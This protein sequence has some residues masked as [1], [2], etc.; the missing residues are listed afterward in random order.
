[1]IKE[2]ITDKDASSSATFCRHFPEGT[3]TYCSNHSAKNLHKNLEKLKKIRCE[4]RILV[5]VMY[6]LLSINSAF[7]MQTNYRR[8]TES[9]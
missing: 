7:P 5:M 6:I 4:V 3:I 2:I 8:A 1:M 9:L